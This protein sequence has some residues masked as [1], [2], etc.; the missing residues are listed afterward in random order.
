MNMSAATL[1]LFG[2]ATG[3]AAA[4]LEWIFLRRILPSAP[5]R[6]PRW[7]VVATLVVLFGGVLAITWLRDTSIG[8]LAPRDSW[9]NALLAY[10][11]PHMISMT[12]L[13]K[14]VSARERGFLRLDDHGHLSAWLMWPRAMQTIFVAVLL[15]GISS[16]AG[17]ATA[18]Y[19]AMSITAAVLALSAA[20][21]VWWR[22]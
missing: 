3:F 2:A 10:V 7:E 21:I 11:V 9:D 18:D 19:P 4:A 8:R 6:K 22:L 17:T 12:A 13:F 15:V 20:A 5:A 14:A 1:A 16:V